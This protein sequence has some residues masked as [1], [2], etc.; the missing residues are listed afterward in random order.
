MLSCWIFWCNILIFK[1]FLQKSLIW[2][3]WSLSII[4]NT[5]SIFNLIVEIFVF[6]SHYGM[7]GMIGTV[8]NI[9]EI[10]N[11]AFHNFLKSDFSFFA[12]AMTKNYVWRRGDLPPVICVNFLSSSTEFFTASALGTK[13]TANLGVLPCS[14]KTTKVKKT[15]VKTKFGE[16]T[17]KEVV[18]V[19]AARTARFLRIPTMQL[20]QVLLF[21][22]FHCSVRISGLELKEKDMN[23]ARL[24][25]YIDWL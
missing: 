25:A 4:S 6:T 21:L 12:Q 24:N 3:P 19:F 23:W 5:C 9:I 14:V 22:P 15:K 7:F 16:I 10:V 2:C 20:T 18:G 13:V 8:N 1:N 17:A 11:C